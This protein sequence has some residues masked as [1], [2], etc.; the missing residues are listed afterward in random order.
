M[1]KEL[2]R[3]YK[4]SGEITLHGDKS[5]SHRAIIFAS[6]ANG[7]SNI[8]NLLLSG[9]TIATLEAFK[10]MGIKVEIEK[11]KVV[12]YGN[13]LKGLTS[14]KG[15]IDS[16]NSGTTA[17]LLIGLLTGQDFESTVVGSE[18]LNKRPMDRVSIP[19]QELGCNI[20][21]DGE[22]LPAV[23]KPGKISKNTVYTNVPSA[24]VKSSL[25]LAAMYSDQPVVIIENSITRDHTE[26]I[27]TYLGIDLVRM[28]NSVTVPPVDEIINFSE[29]IP[30]DISSA[31]F[32]IALGALTESSIRLNNILI[33]E[34]RMG[35][36]KVL[37]QMGADISIEN[38]RPQF[39]EQVGDIKVEKSILES[40]DI[41]EEDIP[42]IID[43]LPVFALVASQAEG[44]TTVNG[45]GELR[46]K[47]SDRLE[48]MRKL[49]S[50]IGMKFEMYED[51]FKII[52]PQKIQS[53][54]VKTYDDHRI[55]MTAVVA[56]LI[57]N[58]EIELDNVN[59]IGDSYPSFFND[60]ESLKGDK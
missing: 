55:A 47:E 18:Q 3:S 51:S 37:K 15:P 28:G 23:I 25:M 17:R 34:S 10:S 41:K 33:N 2:V 30:S 54:H 29:T 60:I 32:L 27:M 38:L 16:V 49:F 48:A 50:S 39:G 9:D 35:F 46:L 11:N 26:R 57:S 8:S 53:G 59:C 12:I 22:N 5:L 45:V 20:K 21:L 40:I 6:I 19:L 7:K 31:S 58:K 1:N 52:G 42:S 14:P 43:E 44:I 24:Q 56:G 4:Y 36:V 13:G